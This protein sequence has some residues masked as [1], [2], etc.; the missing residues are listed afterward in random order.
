MLL[1]TVV[2]GVMQ[3]EVKVVEIMEDKED[4]VIV[5]N[6]NAK[7][8]GLCNVKLLIVINNIEVSGGDSSILI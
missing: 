8:R 3:E 6:I 5:T 1:I 7:T 2:Q 4:L